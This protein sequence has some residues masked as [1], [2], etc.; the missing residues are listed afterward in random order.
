M[1]NANENE[2][3]GDNSSPLDSFDQ[4]E[5]LLALDRK[6]TQNSLD[7]TKESLTNLLH[8]VDQVILQQEALAD[9]KIDPSLLELIKADPT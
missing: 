8:N 6:A 2:R 3:A 9:R 1:A 5:R 7:M 4:V